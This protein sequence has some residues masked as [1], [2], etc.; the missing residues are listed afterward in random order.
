MQNVI[1]WPEHFLFITNTHTAPSLFLIA[2]MEL[3]KLWDELHYTGSLIVGSGVMDL[4]LYAPATLSPTSSM[5]CQP[6]HVVYEAAI[7]IGGAEG[8]D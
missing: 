3:N 8:L 7:Q 6:I 1:T 5:A 4:F 2:V